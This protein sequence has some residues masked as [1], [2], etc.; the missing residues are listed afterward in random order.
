MRFGS[1]PQLDVSYC[2]L[3]NDYDIKICNALLYTDLECDWIEIRYLDL[4]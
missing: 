3:L 4:V 1:F 2:V